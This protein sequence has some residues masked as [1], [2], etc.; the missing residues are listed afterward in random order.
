[1]TPAS[2]C[3]SVGIPCFNRPDGLE[4]TLRCLQQQT[5]SNWT[6][7]ICDNA[8]TDSRVREIS[9]K[10]CREDERCQYR[11]HD[12][13]SGPAANF[14]FAATSATERFFMWASD[15][16]L[17]DPE[18]MNTN[19]RNLRT[20]PSAQMS[21]CSVD[22]INVNDHVIRK[23]KDFSRFSSTGNLNSDVWTFLD[24]PEIMGKA[25]LIYGLFRTE[26]LQGCIEDCWDDAG[27][28]AHGGDVVFLFAFLCRHGIVT[29]DAVHLHKRI[30]T[31]KRSK[32]RRRHPRSY[33]VTK[34]IEFDWY[35]ERHRK[36]APTQEIADMAKRVLRRR[37]SDRIVYSVPM[38]G[39]F[40]DKQRRGL[41]AKAA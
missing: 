18:F 27:F 29:H 31:E 28:D 10:F 15:D 1:M 22:M 36:V 37:R 40:L 3:I 24:D 35:L 25:N 4:N 33:K 13:N 14:H 16:D 5:H 34:A 23:L 11:R 41:R 8:S 39:R 2:D 7:L 32:S 9:E 19:L 30:P 20:T 17:W 21:F 6:A 26:S 38:L 12:R